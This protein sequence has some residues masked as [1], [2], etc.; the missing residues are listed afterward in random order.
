MQKEKEEL[1]ASASSNMAAL[2]AAAVVDKV[3]IPQRQPGTDDNQDAFG[4]LQEH[5]FMHLREDNDRL[6]LENRNL[7]HIVQALRKIVSSL[8]DPAMLSQYIAEE[9]IEEDRNEEE[10]VVKNYF[11]SPLEFTS[12]DDGLFY[13]EENEPPSPS[14]EP[15]LISCEGELL[16]HIASTLYSAPENDYNSHDGMDTGP[17]AGQEIIPPPPLEEQP[18]VMRPLALHLEHTKSTNHEQQKL[19]QSN[20]FGSTY[21]KSK[22][23]SPLTISPSHSNRELFP[24]SLMRSIKSGWTQETQHDHGIDGNHFRGPYLLNRSATSHWT[25]TNKAK[26]HSMLVPL[27]IS[28]QNLDKVY[29]ND[30]A[31]GKT[32]GLR[33]KS[34]IKKTNATTTKIKKYPFMNRVEMELTHVPTLS[35][36][37]YQRSPGKF[38]RPKSP[39]QNNILPM[40]LRKESHRPDT[41]PDKMPKMDFSTRRVLSASSTSR[42][43]KQTEDISNNMDAL[44]TIVRKSSSER[45]A[46]DEYIKKS[47]YSKPAFNNNLSASPH[48]ESTYHG[49]NPIEKE[50]HIQQQV[51]I[52]VLEDGFQME[53]SKGP[54]LDAKVHSRHPVVPSDFIRN[55]EKNLAK[56]RKHIENVYKNVENHTSEKRNII[57]NAIQKARKHCSGKRAFLNKPLTSTEK[58]LAESPLLQHSTAKNHFRF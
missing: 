27:S 30:A 38:Q 45:I 24:G 33:K 4:L 44:E 25:S 32:A 34:K 11:D 43:D 23:M 36:I 5:E 8:I 7:K 14:S 18:Q 54:F 6:F 20:T 48:F 28:N 51:A 47:K 2:T 39:Y 15:L 31:V 17:Q 1:E 10:E 16:Q 13:G 57:A 35:E 22:F 55:H 40:S 58:A 26:Y 53:A 41:A 29:N 49:V 37:D 9:Q 21:D 42:R 50:N 52:R 12:T 19:Q 3:A 46:T 56:E